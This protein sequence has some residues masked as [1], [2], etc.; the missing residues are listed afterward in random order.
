MFWYSYHT[1]LHFEY[2]T[3]FITQLPVSGIRRPFAVL[4]GIKKPQ[5]LIIG[6]NTQKIAK[7]PLDSEKRMESRGFQP[8]C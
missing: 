1:S 4:A 7:N 5:Y 3:M 2:S 8:F 6:N